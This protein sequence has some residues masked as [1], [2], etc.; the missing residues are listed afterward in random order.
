MTELKKFLKDPVF[1][2]PVLFLLGLELFLQT[3]LYRKILE[4]N[5]YAENVNR[6]T[7][8]MKTSPVEP[9]VLILGTSIAY[10][11]VNMPLLNK[12]LEKDGIVVQNGASQGAMLET[13]HSIYRDIRDDLPE[14]QA[15]VHIA[16]IYFPWQARYKLEHANQIMLAQFP[17]AEVLPLLEE[18]RFD[19]S[20]S[21]YA[22]F[23]LR[24][25]TYKQDL[26]DLT[27]SPLDRIKDLGRKWRTSSREYP[28]INDYEFSLAAYGQTREECLAN[29]LEFTKNGTLPEKDGKPISDRH[30][31]QA[32]IDTCSLA[33]RIPV[34]DPGAPEWTSLF[35]HR[36]SIMYGEFKRDD[37]KVITLFAPYS[38]MMP[39]REEQDPMDVWRSELQRIQRGNATIVDMRD[40]LDGPENAGYFYDILHLNKYGAEE[41]TY[42][43]A[44]R[45]RELKPVIL[46]QQN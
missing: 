11:G 13:Q 20:V 40:A 22:F 1:Y 9:N 14:I 45:L 15:V 16:E 28:H 33:S 38:D 39:V 25:L 34:D 31:R 42:L 5:S 7:E 30:H 27:L 3:P 44:E 46:N 29:A 2:V 4:P 43:L 36:L 35:F 18:Y 21:D 6:I 10:Q 12:L 23:L 24:M 8:I 37:V 26:R 32:A 41:F 19:L 17:R